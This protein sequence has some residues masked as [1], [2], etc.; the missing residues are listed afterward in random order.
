MQESQ[1][2][3]QVSC[4]EEFTGEETVIVYLDTKIDYCPGNT[5]G[6]EL[7]QGL[8]QSLLGVK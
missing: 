2:F 4:Y 5:I 6:L 8:G 7:G 3:F 1:S